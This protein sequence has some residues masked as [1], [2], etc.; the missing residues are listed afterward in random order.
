MAKKKS[1]LVVVLCVLAAM[2]F[3]PNIIKW[4][5]KEPT[6]DEIVGTDSWLTIIETDIEWEEDARSIN[7]L[8]GTIKTN[9]EVDAVFVNVNGVGTQ[10]LQ[11]T[12]RLVQTESANYYE[13]TL[14]AQRGLLATCFGGDTVITIDVYVEYAERSYKI[15]T[16]KITVKSAWTD[17]Y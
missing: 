6:T 4:T 7:L 13:Y 8:S 11:H 5:T 2:F 9:E 3:V 14:P 1:W 10:Y 15:D 16:Q 12:S 17:A